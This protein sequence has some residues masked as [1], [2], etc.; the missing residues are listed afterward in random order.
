MATTLANTHCFNNVMKSVHVFPSLS[1]SMNHIKHCQMFPCIALPTRNNKKVINVSSTEVLS[2][3]THLHCLLM[4]TRSGF[5]WG[6]FCFVFSC[7]HP[8]QLKLLQ[9]SRYC[10]SLPINNSSTSTDCVW[11]LL[12]SNSSPFWQCI[13]RWK[14]GSRPPSETNEG[15]RE[16]AGGVIEDDRGRMIKNRGK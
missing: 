7:I 5:L 16:V 14:H 13:I 10:I 6:F 2:T 9:K 11:M 3:E 15:Q 4:N 8:Q 12:L 1:S